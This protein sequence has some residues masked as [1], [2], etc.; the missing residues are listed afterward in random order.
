[1]PLRDFMTATA[2]TTRLPAKSGGK[3]GAPVTNLTNLLICPVM[4][5]AMTGQHNLRAAMGLEGTAVQ[6]FETYTE[7]HS[8]TDSGATVNQLPDI[9]AQDRLVVGS[10][11]Y[12]VRWAE[13]QPA[14]SLFGATLLLYLTE[15]R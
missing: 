12:L 13:I 1:M 4:L 7:A 5:S 2:S 8:H 11:T 10:V 15:D 9:V 3:I 14:T 6:V